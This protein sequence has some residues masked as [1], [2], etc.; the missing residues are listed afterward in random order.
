MVLDSAG[1]RCTCG[2]QGCLEAYA[3]SMALLQTARRTAASAGV[4]R[5]FADLVTRRGQDLTTSDLAM[6]GDRGDPDARALFA[7]VGRRLGQAIGNLVN[8]LD[9][10]RVIVGGG[11]ARAGDLILVP[12]RETVPGLVLAAAARSVP[13]VTAELGSFAAAVG[14]AELIREKLRVD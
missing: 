9:P 6:L 1:P 13:V 4:G 11:V 14:A 7:A 8:V 3:G 12:C 2:G 5:E 10:E